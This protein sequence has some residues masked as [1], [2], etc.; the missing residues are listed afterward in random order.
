MTQTFEQLRLASALCHSVAGAELVLHRRNAPPMT[1]GESGDL[2]ACQF[3]HIVGVHACPLHAVPRVVGIDVAGSLQP[4]T[5]DLFRAR[6]GGREERWF[7]TFLSSSRV[8]EILESLE[9]SDRDARLLSAYVKVDPVLQLTVVA[10]AAGYTDGYSALCRIARQA[11]QASLVEE[12][13][14]GGADPVAQERNLPFQGVASAHDQAEMRPRCVSEVQAVTQLQS[15][16]EPRDHLT[17]P[18]AS[19]SDPNRDNGQ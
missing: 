11:Y 14:S 13:M 6:N 1:V 16:A 3:R 4:V 12:L 7:A 2:S 8:T 10:L 9:C 17:E 15:D 18:A 5:G 19:D